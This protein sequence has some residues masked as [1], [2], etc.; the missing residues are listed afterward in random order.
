MNNLNEAL[1][2]SK[3]M[4]ESMP[5]RYIGSTWLLHGLLNEALGN[6]KEAERDFDNARTCDIC[7]RSYL[8]GNESIT[9]E[10]FPVM[11]RLCRSFPLLGIKFKSRHL[12]VNFNCNKVDGK[13]F[14]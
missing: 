2:K 6:D 5:E 3:E 8:D 13:T 11:S 12:L 4:M 7:S 14:I 9:L 1:E 10:I